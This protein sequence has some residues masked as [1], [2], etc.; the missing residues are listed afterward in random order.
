MHVNRSLQALKD[1]LKPSARLPVVFLGHGSP[2][3]AVQE[4]SYSKS[5]TELG[6]TLPRPQAILMISAHWMTQG[7]TLVDVSTAP[8]TIHDFHGFPDE[9]FAQQY[10]AQGA[11]DMAQETLALLASHHA[12]GDDS[13]G[14]DHGSWSVL[15]WVYP[16]ADVPVF[17][18][19]IDMSKDLPW[20]LEISRSLRALRDRGVLIMG[21]G[22]VVHNLR[23]LGPSGS[24]HHW[25][26]EFDQLFADKLIDG[27]FNALTDRKSLGKLFDMAH[28]SVD[29][30]L[31]ALSIAGAADERDQLTFMTEQID[32]G[33]ISMRSFIYH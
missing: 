28:P 30:Y 4:S 17:Q 11:P 33:A 2:M 21:S 14:L 15:K 27:D 25:A 7:S 18:L 32:L 3:N 31:P 29:H 20:H 9:L 16:E 22:N 10:P 23:A 24:A 13:W 6:Q 5:W 8:R 19:S 1:R 26:T 12:A